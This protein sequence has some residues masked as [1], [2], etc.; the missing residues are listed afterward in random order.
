MKQYAYLSQFSN[1]YFQK[2]LIASGILH[3][4]VVTLTFVA[5]Y[6]HI[7]KGKQATLKY[8]STVR[9]DIIDLPDEVLHKLDQPIL[10]TQ[11]AIQ[12]LRKN[13]ETDYEDPDA[14]QFKSKAAV[15]KLKSQAHSAI[16][17]L[18]SLQK[19]ETEKIAVKKE[20]LRKGNVQTPGASIPSAAPETGELLDAYGSEVREKIKLRWALPF[21]LRQKED[22][23]G[24]LT[25]Y[26][27]LDG[28]LIRKEIV[29]SGNKDFDDFMNRALEE[30]LPFVKVPENIQRDVRY[31][32][33]V[34]DFY[35]KELM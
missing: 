25:I 24:K 23:S 13:I 3:F 20:V 16:A 30:S 33:I 22:L 8:A 35:A 26:L 14:L 12:S 6:I 31:D 28:Y 34:I 10:S 27:D 17:R 18:K 9:V 7:L 5:P 29:S 15:E 2:A 4:L 21:Y 1:V 11:D 32:G 19:L